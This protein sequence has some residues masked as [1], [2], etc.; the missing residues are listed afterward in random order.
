M[1]RPT[2]LNSFTS[3]S[4]RRL[5]EL[6]NEAAKD[7]GVL[8]V[9]L[10]GQGRAFCSGVDLEELSGDQGEGGRRLGE[11]FDALIEVA[12]RLRQAARRRRARSCGGL[13]CHDPVALRRRLGG[14]RRAAAVSRSRHSARHPKRG[15]A[16]SCPRS[17]VRSGPPSCS[18]LR[19]GSTRQKPCST[20]W[21]S[22]AVRAKRLDAE[23]AALADRIAQ[24]PAEAVASAKRLLRASRSDLVHAASAR[25]RAEAGV[26]TAAFGPPGHGG[27]PR[28][29]ASPRCRFPGRRTRKTRRGEPRRVDRWCGDL[30]C[31]GRPRCRDRRDQ[32]APG[33]SGRVALVRSLLQP[34]LRH[35]LGGCYQPVAAM[36]DPLSWVP[37]MEPSLGASP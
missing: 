26:L 6:L 8:V 23:V 4:Y 35:P 3:A 1:N 11:T 31:T 9:V 19:A 18:S 16:C 32:D 24:Q 12:G 29:G 15:A 17:S 2:R 27:R 34:D 20:G 10:R 37:S 36:M 7:P 5:A 28:D 25:E 30:C 14:R 13:R 22:R 33:Q 21:R